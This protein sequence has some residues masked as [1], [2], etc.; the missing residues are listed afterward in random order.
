MAQE[1]ARIEEEL[2]VIRL[3]WDERKFI[4]TREP[5]TK[6]GSGHKLTV[7]NQINSLNEEVEQ[8]DSVIDTMIHSSKSTFFRPDLEKM[9]G[10]LAEITAI[11]KTWIST[12]EN[13]LVL[14]R[15][16]LT[17]VSADF[18]EID[19]IRLLFEEDFK[20]YNKLMEEV[21]KVK[22]NWSSFILTLYF[23]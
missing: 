19:D 11:L 16:L 17:F 4:L 13:C 22:K 5:I 23:F 1:E 21:A 18:R 3:R 14:A 15:V 6:T 20:S 12:Q 9:K 2:T 8:D 7:I 10:I